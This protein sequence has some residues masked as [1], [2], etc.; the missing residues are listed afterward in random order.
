M[1]W[2]NK[3]FRVRDFF[4]LILGV[5]VMQTL[6]CLLI[7]RFMFYPVKGGYDQSLDG[8]VSI[9]TNGENVAARVLGPWRGRRA[10]LFCHGNAEDLTSL[11]GR[12][13]GLVAEGVT[14]A[15]FDYPGYGLSD[16]SPSEAGCYRNCHALYDWMIHTRGFAPEDIFVVGFSIG[17]GIAVE[18]AVARDVGGL[19]LEAPYLSTPR[20][21]TRMRLL[22]IDPFPNIGRIGNVHC[23]VVVMH[24]TRDGVIPFSQGRQ[25]FEAAPAPKRFIAVDGAGHEDLITSYGVKQYERELREFLSKK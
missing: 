23:P 16:G 6:A 4:V 11:D 25:L 24:G 10:I 13:D 20:V 5:I 9:E 3:I 12:F 14:V 17:S 8:Y 18:L 19:W 22:V 7:N 1:A 15:T 2:I 21:V